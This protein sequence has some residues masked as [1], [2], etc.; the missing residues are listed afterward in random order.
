MCRHVHDGEA[1]DLVPVELALR[2][3]DGV[4]DVDEDVLTLEALGRR[5]VRDILESEEDGLALD[6]CRAN[7][8][9]AATDDDHIATLEALLGKIGDDAALQ[10]AADTV[11]RKDLRHH[12][13][14]VRRRRGRRGCL[15][16]WRR[17]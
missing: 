5:A 9:N 14:I 1:Y 15:C 3:R 16:G 2:E 17:L 4:V 11:W 7:R 6:P 12:Q 8:V 10:L 13:V